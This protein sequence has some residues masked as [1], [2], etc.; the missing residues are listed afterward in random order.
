MKVRLLKTYRSLLKSVEKEIMKGNIPREVREEPV[1]FRY[2]QPIHEKLFTGNAKVHRIEPPLIHYSTRD[3][4]DYQRKLW[5][6]IPLEIKFMKQQK[7]KV[8]RW[9]ILIRPV[10]KFFYIYIWQLGFLDGLTGLQYAWLSAFA[11]DYLKY[12]GY[13]RIMKGETK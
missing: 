3:I 8:Y 9:D 13:Y 5:L 2:T 4:E 10:M 12:S 11:Y 7:I 6:Y 1:L